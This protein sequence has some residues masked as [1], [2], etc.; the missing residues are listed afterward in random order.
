MSRFVELEGCHNFRDLGGY[1]SSDGRRVRRGLVYR[2]AALHGLTEGDRRRVREELGVRAIIDLRTEHE[3]SVEGPG[4]VAAPPVRYHNVPLIIRPAETRGP[5][6]DEPF[7]LDRFYLGLMEHGAPRV[8]AVIELLAAARTPVVFHCAAGKDRTGVISAVVLAL[9]G[10]PEAELIE[11]YALTQRALGGVR[12][13]LL[14]SES[15]RQMWGDLPP[16]SLHAL[17]ETMTLLLGR[18]AQRWGSMLDYARA[19]GLEI[20][21]IEELRARLLD[22]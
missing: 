5:R 1:T 12:R 11:D 16:A 8:R 21:A 6:L 15:Y 19:I 20:R 9:L 10:V 14:A 18:V 22:D 2:A 7:E 13:Q 4:D 17:P 3:V